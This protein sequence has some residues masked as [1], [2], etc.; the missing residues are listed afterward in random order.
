MKDDSKKICVLVVESI[1]GNY[2]IKSIWDD[3]KNDK[4][5]TEGYIRIRVENFKNQI[6]HDY[7]NKSIE[8]FG[9]A[10]N[11]DEI[12][13]IIKIEDLPEDHMPEQLWEKLK[14]DKIHVERFI[15]NTLE[16]IKRRIIRRLDE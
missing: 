8:L 9:Q 15:E 11:L 2:D 16:M 10:E 7:K 1:S 6:I 14:T 4:E 5:K 12:T 3:L 13:Q